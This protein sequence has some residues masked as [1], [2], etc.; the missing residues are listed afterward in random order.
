MQFIK[1]FC[2]AWGSGGVEG[3]RGLGVEKWKD[4]RME[5]WRGIGLKPEV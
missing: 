2:E 1:F 4:G 5:G 3:W